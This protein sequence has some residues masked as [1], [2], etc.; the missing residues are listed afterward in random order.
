VIANTLTFPAASSFKA[1]LP[2]WTLSSGFN[3][4]NSEI[5]SGNN[6]WKNSSP[7]FKKLQYSCS[8]KRRSGRWVHARISLK[9]PCIEEGWLGPALPEKWSF[10]D[11]KFSNF[12]NFV[13]RNPI[14]SIISYNGNVLLRPLK[15]SVIVDN[16]SCPGIAI[17]LKT[18]KTVRLLRIATGSP[19]LKR[20]LRRPGIIRGN[21]PVRS[22]GNPSER[23]TIFPLMKCWMILTHSL[24]YLTVKVLPLWS[25][26]VQMLEPSF[27]R[28]LRSSPRHQLKS[29][30]HVENIAKLV[31]FLTE[32]IR[33]DLILFKVFMVEYKIL[34]CESWL[35]VRSR[36]PRPPLRMLDNI[37]IIPM[38]PAGRTSRLPE[39]FLQGRRVRNICFLLPLPNTICC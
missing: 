31:M 30:I 17:T 4:F 32:P 39:P 35:I 15:G 34:C 13:D 12:G 29:R 3:S 21:P 24:Q 22:I 37:T 5:E 2:K 1:S 10:T 25:V 38:S 23:V 16:L 28:R 19:D 33:G 18:L 11:W 8:F 26:R 7:P 6:A 27:I 14:P 36:Y 9:I 20:D